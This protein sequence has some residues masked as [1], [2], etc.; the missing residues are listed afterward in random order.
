MTTNP[1]AIKPT[2]HDDSEI[3]KDRERQLQTLTG[4]SERFGDSLTTAF[5]K[6][7]AE[8]KKF[9]DVL[10]SVRR[11]LV[12]QCRGRCPGCFRCPGIPRC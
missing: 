11:S 3:K 7:I 8:G 12:V 1:N 10:K 6:N 4:L 9:D 2:D 5:A